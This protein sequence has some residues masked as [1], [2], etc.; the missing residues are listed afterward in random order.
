M[1]LHRHQSIPL[2]TLE[3]NLYGLAYGC[4]CIEREK[5][6]PLK[7][8]DDLCFKEKLKWIE[9]LSNEEKTTILKYHQACSKTR[10]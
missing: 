3:N 6:C 8:I 2:M 5:E 4:P 10:Y 1:K 7:D 9:R